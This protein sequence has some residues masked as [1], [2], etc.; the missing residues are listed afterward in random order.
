MHELPE[1]NR[2]EHLLNGISL[3]LCLFNIGRFLVILFFQLFLSSLVQLFD[4]LF[5]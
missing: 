3:F 1:L 4:R 5:K 2:N